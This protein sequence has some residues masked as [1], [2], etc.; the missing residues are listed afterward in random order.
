M[1]ET[2]DSSSFFRKVV[3]FVANPGTEWAELDVPLED[4]REVDY[5]KGELKAMIERKR[6]ND[7]VRKREFDMLRKVR[8]EGLSPEQLAALGTSRLDDSEARSVETPARQDAGV[9]A[10]IDEIEQQMV[11]DNYATTQRRG[12]E[13]YNAPTQPVP[14]D[15]AGAR[16]P[17]AAGAQGARVEDF[18]PARAAKPRGAAPTPQA[19]SLAPISLDMPASEDFG[20][21]FSVAAST[22]VAHDPDLDEAVIAFANADFDQCEQALAQLT[23]P[24]G[25]RAQHAETWLVLFDLYRATGQ[26]HKFESLALDYAQQ[27]GW[28]APQWYSLPKL[29][30]EAASEERP[31]STR[32]E[33]QVGWVCPNYLDADGVAKL[34]SLA[35]QMPLPWVFDWA[36]LRNID[37]EA[38]GRLSELFRSWIPQDLD[39]RW[40]SGERLFTVLQDAAPNSVRDADPAFWQLRLDALR[41]TN[42]PDQFDEAAIDYCVTYEVSPPSWEPA[43]CVVRVTG[44]NQG[45]TQPPMSQ[46]S[47][48]A[49]SFQESQLTDDPGV[50]QVGTLELSGQLVGDISYTLSKMDSQLG[51]TKI[52]N[53][54]CVKL[55]RV[56]FIGAG[57]LLNWVLARRNE[58]RTV[59]FVD[60]HRMVALFFGAMGINEHATVKVR[61]L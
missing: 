45:T 16:P 18:V 5:A 38:S 39:M 27:F 4:T 34:A 41:M 33:G 42:R 48:V 21:A 61:T 60:C 59:N 44:S 52:L 12:P 29:V 46:V 6:R 47:D 7:F 26:Q 36:A 8:R 22:E 54:S 20:K 32:I 13:F 31:T 9:K 49:T 10:K 58:G 3:K 23:G 24:G 28:S 17:A 56:D 51:T 40:L 2:K 19:A 53:V 43:R 35:L 14:I 25:A 15:G 37:A 55:I 30:A 50:V 1:A 57:D 11:G